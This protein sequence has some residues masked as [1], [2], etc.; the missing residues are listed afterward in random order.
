MEIGGCS[1]ALGSEKLK[2]VKKGAEANLYLDCLQGREVIIKRRFPKKYRNPILDREIRYR[3]TIQE[4]QLIHR[5]KKAGVPSPTIFLIDSGNTSIIMEY[6]KGQ[7]VKQILSSSEGE[8][9]D[10][11][12]R[13]GKLIGCLHKHGIVHGDL[14]T[15]NMILTEK[16]RVVLIDFG[17]GELTEELEKRGVDLHLMKRSLHSTHY[18]HA[19]NYFNFIMIGYKK[20]IGINESEKVFRRIREIESRGRYI[21][22]RLV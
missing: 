11:F 12:R 5:A 19:E 22:E 2:L 14:T 7:Q 16:K 6:I 8:F 15:S 13:I 3:R 18:K 4:S 10:L 17:L 1:S 21:A 9:N 20:I